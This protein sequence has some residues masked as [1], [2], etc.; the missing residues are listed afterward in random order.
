MCL[1]S[2]ALFSDAS[3]FPAS[4]KTKHDSHTT[5]AQDRED[6]ARETLLLEDYL[7]EYGSEAVHQETAQ[8]KQQ[9]VAGVRCVAVAGNR[10]Y[11]QTLCHATCDNQGN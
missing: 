2:D 6:K 8:H 11:H 5:V 7:P 3:S 1:Q 10:T 4:N 9:A